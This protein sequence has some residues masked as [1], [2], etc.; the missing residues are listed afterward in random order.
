MNAGAIKI[1]LLG[2]L[3]INPPRGFTVFGFTIYLYGLIIALGFGLAALYLYRRRESFGLTRDNVLDIFI[4]AVAGGLV[5]ARLYY[6]A[7]NPSDYFGAGKWLNIFKFREG[8]L[9]VFGGIILAVASVAVYSRVRRLRLAPILDGGALG[10]LIGQSIGR[11]GNFL[12][13]EAHGSVTS[14]P[15]RMGIELLPG[16]GNFVF[17]HPTF[18][19]ESLWN[20][21]GLLLLHLFSKSK[22]R[23]YDGQVFLLYALWYGVGRALIEGLRTDSLYIPGTE[24]R[25]SQALAAVC[26]AASC[27]ILIIKAAGRNKPASPD[28]TPPEVDIGNEVSK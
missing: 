28:G 6:V 25:A 24:I 12:N 21:I 3:E 1:P 8:G 23:R 14:L 19:Y 16:S 10:L 7:F 20:A 15:W 26:A 27:A 9:A 5:G 17:V 2:G 4:C 11:W 22:L 13:R 18:L